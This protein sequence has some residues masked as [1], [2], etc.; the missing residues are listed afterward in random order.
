MLPCYATP[1]TQEEQRTKRIKERGVGTYR[2]AVQVQVCYTPRSP[3][4]RQQARPTKVWDQPG[5]RE[6]NR[7]EDPRP[8]TPLLHRECNG[9]TTSNTRKG[10][11]TGRETEAHHGM[12][13]GGRSVRTHVDTSAKTGM[14]YAAQRST[15]PQ[16]TRCQRYTKTAPSR[17]RPTYPHP[18]FVSQGPTREKDEPARKKTET[19][20]RA[21][22]RKK[23]MPGRRASRGKGK[24]RRSHERNKG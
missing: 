9:A 19:H 2:V 18:P 22:A 12:A 4:A 15:Q 10:M 20:T 21:E 3:D 24:E 16:R 13:R 6:G 23:C 8:R 1:C 14:L 7:K 11:G 17:R 5:S